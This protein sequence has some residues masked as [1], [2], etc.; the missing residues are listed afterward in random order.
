MSPGCRLPSAL[1]NGYSSQQLCAAVSNAS[2]WQGSDIVWFNLN[3][4]FNFSPETTEPPVPDD[5]GISDATVR[6]CSWAHM[7][8]AVLFLSL[9][10]CAVT[11]M[12]MTMFLLCALAG[13]KSSSLTCSGSDARRVDTGCVVRGFLISNLT[14]A[15]S[16]TATQ[17]TTNHH[18]HLLDSKGVQNQLTMIDAAH[19][20]D[21]SHLLIG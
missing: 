9:L 13:T 21:C 19:A 6:W 12:P 16:N 18:P 11:S 14:I 7:D 20:A 1:R 8:R 10:D 2:N 17:S 5:V 15:T 4:T 3:F